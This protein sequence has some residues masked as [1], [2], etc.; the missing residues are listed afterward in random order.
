MIDEEFP[1]GISLERARGMIEIP[2]AVSVEDREEFC[3]GWLASGIVG[4]LRTLETV[5]ENERRD[6]QRAAVSELRLTLDRFLNSTCGRTLIAQL[7]D[8][9]WKGFV[10]EDAIGEAHA[11]REDYDSAE[12]ALERVEHYFDEAAA[13]G[14]PA[15]PA[16]VASLLPFRI[17]QVTEREWHEILEDGV[18]TIDREP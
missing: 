18:P 11:L 17:R 3:P 13:C 16:H 14:H 9:L 5:D 7:T 4:A 10:I 15:A 12:H 8:R 6:P 2:A 1:P